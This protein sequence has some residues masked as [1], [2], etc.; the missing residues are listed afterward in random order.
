MVVRCVSRGVAMVTAKLRSSR[1]CKSSQIE[2]LFGPVTLLKL[3]GATIFS[4]I[5]LCFG[6]YQL[7]VKD[8]NMSRTTFKTSLL[9]FSS[10]TLIYL[11]A[12]IEH[13][14]H[15]SIV[16]QTLRKRQLLGKFIGFLGH[17]VSTNDIRVD[18]SKIS[19]ILNWKPLKS[20]TKSRSFLGL[21]GYYT[22]FVKGFS[23]IA[24]PLTKLLQK[25]VKFVSSDKCQ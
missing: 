15:L 17:V 18:P 7:R 6:Y 12:E 11:R 9:L 22:F 23:M 1:G 5:D 3:K 19:A 8:S 2:D 14:W 24:L 25:D 16:L 21:A 10:M 13:V 4:K 20:V